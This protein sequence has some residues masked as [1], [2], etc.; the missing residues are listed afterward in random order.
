MFNLSFAGNAAM[1]K[2]E[3]NQIQTKGINGFYAQGN[4]CG[5][6]DDVSVH[7]LFC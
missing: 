7:W 6:Q 3:N 4:I 2:I 1:A 5:I